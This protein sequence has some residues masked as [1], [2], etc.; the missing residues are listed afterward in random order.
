MSV[1]VFVLEDLS[2]AG[3]KFRQEIRGHFL[4]M[5]VFFFCFFFTARSPTAPTKSA[6]ERRERKREGG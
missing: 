3:C 2:V 4:G 6:T 5:I 1:C